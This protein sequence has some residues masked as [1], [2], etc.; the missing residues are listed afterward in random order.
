[1][2]K[3]VRHF[4]LT[5][6]CIYRNRGGG[7]Y[8]CLSTTGTHDPILTNVASGWTF[9]A[10]TITMYQDG[11]IE[12]DYSTGGTWRNGIPVLEGTNNNG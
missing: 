12:W 11:T 9:T 2:D 1:M 7:T 6:G 5:K 8:L 10:H 3:G 4:K